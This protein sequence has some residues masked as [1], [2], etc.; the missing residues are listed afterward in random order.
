MMRIRPGTAI[1]LVALFLAVAG[2]TAVALKGHNS[3]RSDDIVN[4]QVKSQDL[5]EAKV[6]AVKPNPVGDTDPCASRATGVFCGAGS[7]SGLRGW[8]N[9][10]A[11]DA[12]VTYS[13]DDLGMVRLSGSMTRSLAAPIVSTQSFI[14]PPAYRPD[15]VHQF[16][17][18]MGQGESCDGGSCDENLAVIEVDPNG[19]VTA[20]P[21]NDSGSGTDFGNGVSLDGVAYQAK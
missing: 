20:I 10:G 3:V 7:L 8:S 6:V 15:A 11:P 14:L 1:A 18:A 12:S 13:R 2:G 9:Y 4:G 5:A 21:G 17:V 16:A 19:D